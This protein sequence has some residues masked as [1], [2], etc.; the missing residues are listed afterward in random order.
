LARRGTKGVFVARSVARPS[1]PAASRREMEL[2]S[3][4]DVTTRFVLFFFLSGLSYHSLTH[5]N[6]VARPGWERVCPLGKSRW[7]KRRGHFATSVRLESVVWRDVCCAG[8]INVC[9]IS[10]DIITTR[11]DYDL[12]WC[13]TLCLVYR[14]V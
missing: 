14:L 4:I 10:R 2:L 9:S 8:Y 7:L 13:H 12:T 11:Y 6:A 3:A 5:M 1:I